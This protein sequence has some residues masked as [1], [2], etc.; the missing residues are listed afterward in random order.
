[1][2]HRNE[3]SYQDIRHAYVKKIKP[4]CQ[5]AKNEGNYGYQ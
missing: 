5:K 4:K 3:A 2:Y 1:M